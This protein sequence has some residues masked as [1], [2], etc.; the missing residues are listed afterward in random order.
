MLATIFNL[1]ITARSIY[2]GGLPYS[3]TKSEV[4]N[5]IKQFGQVR[6]SSDSIQIRKHKVC[7]GF[8][9]IML[10]YNFIFVSTDSS[11]NLSGWI[12]LRICGI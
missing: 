6:R 9:L 10:Y 1:L 2:I 8:E 4:L 7:F 3:I 12:L 5:I 11:Q